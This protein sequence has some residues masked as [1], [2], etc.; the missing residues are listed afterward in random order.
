MI[1]TIK[2]HI[3]VSGWVWAALIIDTGDDDIEQGRHVGP[4]PGVIPQNGFELSH[5]LSYS[6]RKV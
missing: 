4:P 5:G 3:P 6:F 2:I 1:P